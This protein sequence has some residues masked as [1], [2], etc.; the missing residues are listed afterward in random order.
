[1]S[2]RKIID[3]FWEPQIYGTHRRR[4]QG[5][6]G[7]VARSLRYWEDWEGGGGGLTHNRN[8]HMP[9]MP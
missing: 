5:D 6:R 2:T 8:R 7:R 4:N 3:R 1:M 9:F